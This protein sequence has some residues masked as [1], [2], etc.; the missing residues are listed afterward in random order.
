MLF[1]SSRMLRNHRHMPGVNAKAHH[2]G[3]ILPIHGWAGRRRSFYWHHPTTI[4]SFDF[5]LQ[6]MLHFVYFC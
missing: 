4:F 3:I 6:F 5:L 2:P 1:F